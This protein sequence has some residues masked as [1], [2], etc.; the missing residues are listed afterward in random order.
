[1][2]I[3]AAAASGAGSTTPVVTSMPARSSST[4]PSADPS[5]SPT[6][7]SGSS[8]DA[9]DENAVAPV[10]EALQA[11]RNPSQAALSAFARYEC[12]ADGALIDPQT[13]EAA[14]LPDNPLRP[15]VAC[16][17]P[18]ASTSDMAR[19]SRERDWAPT[20]AQVATAVVSTRQ[21]G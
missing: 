2:P 20:T 7:E 11:A 4:T 19:P 15:L 14:N 6:E 10:D 8:S 1:M 18:Q 5:A 13:G 3:A 21:P 12:D 17:A 9:A 16:E